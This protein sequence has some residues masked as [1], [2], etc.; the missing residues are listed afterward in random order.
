MQRIE[1]E[2]EDDHDVSLER[3]RSRTFP[4]SPL[5]LIDGF[6]RRSFA[7]NKLPEKPLKLSVHK[8]DGTCF[9]IEVPK[10]GTVANLKQAV[11]SAFSHVPKK[12]PEKISWSHVWGQFCLCYDVR[13]LVT[14]TECIRDLGIKDG[15][16]LFFARHISNKCNLVKKRSRKQVLTWKRC[17][18]SS[19]RSNGYE[20]NKQDGD[21]EEDDD[22]TDQESFNK[23]EGY[24]SR[25]HKLG[26][27]FRRW[28]SHSKLEGEKRRFKRTGHSSRFTKVL[29]GGDRK[30]VV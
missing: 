5:L 17:R 1:Q 13:K 29:L 7:Y 3:R 15:D 11:E 26:R 12:G 6:S 24:L 16:Q 23:K 4:F 10:R 25:H 19:S 21:D 28:F 22:Y 9:E 14:E 20:A 2:K 18:L 27:V 8:L 30:S